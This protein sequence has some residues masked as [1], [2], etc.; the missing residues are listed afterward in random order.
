MKILVVNLGSTSTKAGIYEGKT[1]LATETI[2][3]RKEEL[4]SLHTLLE[5]R[6]FRKGV[7]ESWL[8]AQG[9]SLDDFAV[10]SL[11]GG[12]IRPIPGG[13][14]Q[15]N[16]TVA[17]DARSGHYGEHACNVGLLLGY[18]WSRSTGIPA[19]FV[20]APCTDELSEVARISGFKGVER[21]SIFHALNAKRVIRLYCKEKGLDPYGHSFIVAHMGGGISVS[22]WQ[23]LKAIDINNGVDGEGP[24]SPERVGSLTHKNIFSLLKEYGGD[25]EA[26]RKALY[27]R[28]GLMS[29][30]G[31]NDAPALTK[32][33][34]TEP[35]VALI[36]DAMIYNIAKQIGA[37]AIPIKGQVEQILLTGGLAHNPRVTAPICEQVAWIAGCTI[38]PGED[39]LA[40]LAEGAW[41][42]V[43]GQEEALVI[44]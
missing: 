19:V 21:T 41:R 27:Y 15:I 20:D 26:L 28:G 37:L 40:A 7:I 25:T 17:E 5:Q 6:D 14:Y 39:E 3:H 31:T 18:D 10:F 16:A 11:R 42:F 38:Y 35:E 24:F 12:L 1:S 32:R 8:L 44:E 43:T 2:R 36:L 4:A 30:F 23:K 9:Y 34:E 29:Y 13:V 33:A 22:A